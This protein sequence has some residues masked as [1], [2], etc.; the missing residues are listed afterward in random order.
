MRKPW[1]WG[2]SILLFCPS[3]YKRHILDILPPDLTHTPQSPTQ[4]TFL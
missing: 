4:A 2:K 1:E 3:F